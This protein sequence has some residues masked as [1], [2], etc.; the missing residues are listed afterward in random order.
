MELP[1]G[2]RAAPCMRVLVM[3]LLH[4]EGWIE[5]GGSYG[6]EFS[7]TSMRAKGA[8]SIS[9]SLLHGTI[10]KGGEHGWRTG[11]KLG[12]DSG[13]RGRARR[14]PRSRDRAGWRADRQRRRRNVNRTEDHEDHGGC[15]SRR[16][17]QVA[18]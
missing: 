17:G 6:S 7:S 8:A 11:G 12:R 16:I 3:F 10:R 15:T 18:S 13:T 4:T 1:E 5:K 2:D 14:P 9:A